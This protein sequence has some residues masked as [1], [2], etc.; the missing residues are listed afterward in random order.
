VCHCH[1]VTQVNT[2]RRKPIERPITNLLLPNRKIMGCIVQEWENETQ[3]GGGV[4]QNQG[5]GRGRM[6]MGNLVLS[7]LGSGGG[8][9]NMFLV[10]S[11]GKKME[12]RK[13][14]VREEEERTMRHEVKEEG[15]REREGWVG[16]G[17]PCAQYCQECWWGKGICLSRAPMERG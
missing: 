10:S 4:M 7:V 9:G 14:W 16:N 13:Q 5:R 3:G 11:H 12:E 1:T 15:R 17:E 6:A 8:E 2:R